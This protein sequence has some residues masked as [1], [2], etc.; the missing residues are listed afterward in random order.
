MPAPVV[1]EGEQDDPA[2]IA[3][4]ASDRRTDDDLPDR[5]HDRGPSVAQSPQHLGQAVHCAGL[6][7]SRLLPDAHDLVEIIL[8]EIPNSRRSHALSVPR[9]DPRR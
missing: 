6:R 7:A 8:M 3:A 9:A 4:H 5:G 2:T 1:R